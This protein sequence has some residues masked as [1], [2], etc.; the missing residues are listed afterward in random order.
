MRKKYSKIPAAGIAG[1]G[2]QCGSVANPNVANCQLGRDKRGLSRNAQDARCPSSAAKMA[3]PHV[4]AVAQERD[5]P[6]W[7]YGVGEKAVFLMRRI[8]RESIFVKPKH[9]PPRSFSEAPM[10]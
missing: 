6:A 9:L 3:A 5:P 1:K 8:S 10:R 4:A 7:G 2:C